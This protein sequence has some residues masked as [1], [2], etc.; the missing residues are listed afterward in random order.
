MRSAGGVAKK[1]ML[2]VRAKARTELRASRTLLTACVP[3]LMRGDAA[4]P[5]I[6]GDRGRRPL[7]CRAAVYPGRRNLVGAEPRSLLMFTKRGACDP[8]VR[9]RTRS[10]STRGGPVVR[11]ARGLRMGYAM[12]GEGRGAADRARAVRRLRAGQPPR[13]G[14]RP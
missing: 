10:A 1:C 5:L 8:G 2:F 13:P 7:V 11:G 9:R 4:T 6:V 12:M 3:A 14:K